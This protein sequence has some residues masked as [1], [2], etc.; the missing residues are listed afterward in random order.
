MKLF[1]NAFKL[2]AS[3]LLY[4]QLVTLS[5]ILIIEIIATLLIPSWRDYFY[6]SLVLYN[7]PSFFIAVGLFIGLM[8]SLTVAQGLKTW[9]AQKIALHLRTG[10]TS[11]LQ[12]K[13]IKANRPVIV[14]S[15]QRINQDTALSTD[16]ALSVIIEVI[17]SGVI[18]IALVV[19]AFYQPKLILL[20]LGYTLIVSLFMF[21]FKNKLVSRDI[22][23]Q[24]VEASHRES[25]SQVFNSNLFVNAPFRDSNVIYNT[26]KDAYTK[27][28]KTVMHYSLFNRMQNNFSIV[29]AYL[30][31]AP[32]YFTKD[33][34]LGQFMGDVAIF[35]LIV[36]NATILTQLFPNMTKSI[37]SWH[38][39]QAFNKLME[40]NSEN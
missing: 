30:I 7:L 8:G 12:D 13:Y 33:I 1:I 6:T 23:L 2:I 35:E 40:E 9:L 17:I 24:N 26:V 31:I 25:L 10:L 38:R 3:K 4:F 11:Y 21:I 22:T 27:F 34:T 14:N 16:L 20:A 15:S 18:V 29:I 28:I 32:L 36:I 19:Q 5:I 37:A 39:L